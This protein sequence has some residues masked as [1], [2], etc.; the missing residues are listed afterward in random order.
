MAQLEV[1]KVTPYQSDATKK[2]QIREMFDNIANRYDSLNR[3]MSL[4]IDKSWRKKA[5]NYIGEKNPQTILDLATGTG[6]FAIEALRL[7]PAK[8]VGLDLSEE[9]MEIG[10]K[11][12]RE[13][14][15][16]AILTFQQGESENMPFAD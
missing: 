10:R 3:L 12:A 6:D 7:K 15:S 2:E 13:H 8:I 9:M 1:E 4:G 5:V 14:N 11:K 16:E